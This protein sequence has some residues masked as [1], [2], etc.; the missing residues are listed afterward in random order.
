VDERKCR[1]QISA[2]VNFSKS[3]MMKGVIENGAQKGIRQAVQDFQGALMP[4]IVRRKLSGMNTCTAWLV[5]LS[6]W[7][8]KSHRTC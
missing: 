7:P 2:Q 3:T 8:K 1:L 4:F 5:F 6:F